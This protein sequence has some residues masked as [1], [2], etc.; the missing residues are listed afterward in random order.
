MGHREPKHFHLLN[1]CTCTSPFQELKVVAQLGHCF[2][3][4]GCSCWSRYCWVPHPFE[5][6]LELGLVLQTR[7]I[8]SDQGTIWWSPKQE[9]SCRKLILSQRCCFFQTCGL[10]GLCLQCWKE[11]QWMQ[12]QC[13][14]IWEPFSSC[15]SSIPL[16]HP[17]WS[18]HHSRP[19]PMALVSFCRQPLFVHYRAGSFSRGQLKQKDDCKIKYPI[20]WKL[21][22]VLTIPNMAKGIP[23]HC[24]ENGLPHV[25]QATKT[26]RTHWHIIPM[27]DKS[28]EMFFHSITWIHYHDIFFLTGFWDK[29]SSNL[30]G[31]LYE[32][33]IKSFRGFFDDTC[34][35]ITEQG[36]SQIIN[37][38]SLITALWKRK[39]LVWDLALYSLFYLSLLLNHISFT[40]GKITMFLEEGILFSK[41]DSHNLLQFDDGSLIHWHSHISWQPKLLPIYWLILLQMFI[42]KNVSK[43][44]DNK[45][46][47]CKFI[48]QTN[49][50]I[51]KQTNKP[52]PRPRR[53]PQ[54][55]S[56][57][58]MK[59]MII[60]ILAF[61]LQSSSK[62]CSNTSS[63]P[64]ALRW[65]TKFNAIPMNVPTGRNAE[66]MES[67]LS[68]SENK[69]CFR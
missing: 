54:V 3:F 14:H 57:A 52:G 63:I 40:T 16:F 2:D 53:I 62:T 13:P 29:V 10:H 15:L 7:W 58:Q 61:I 39:N 41:V 17:S 67:K 5:E 50:K 64:S 42:R 37:W 45:L 47:N 65:F 33:T 43:W 38:I 22:S 31:W 69:G 25:V 18:Q 9:S 32:I 24:L 27:F 19:D 60:S 26:C 20:K 44:C 51:S 49:I 28:I 66:L 4:E 56:L 48:V 68:L 11:P 35:V 36:F 12:R 34:N 30:V 55:G 46:F 1:F 23:I 59:N 21:K 6:V 8:R